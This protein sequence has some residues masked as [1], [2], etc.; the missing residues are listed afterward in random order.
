MT[1]D[2][3]QWDRRIDEGFFSLVR[4]IYTDS[5]MTIS[6]GTVEAGIFLE[7]LPGAS[8][9]ALGAPYFNEHSPRE[10]FDISELQISY[11]RLRRLLAE[12]KTFTLGQLS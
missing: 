5:P 3:P 12:L 1:R 9:I 7:K 6:E 10:Y 4:S 8:Y 11:E 2:L